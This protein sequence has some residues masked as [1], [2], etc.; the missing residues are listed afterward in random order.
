[1]LKLMIFFLFPLLEIYA[2][3]TLGG[4]I[5]GLNVVLLVFASAVLGVWVVR[6]H[7]QQCLL[8]VREELGAGRVPQELLLDNLFVFVA[9]VLL[10]LPGPISDTVGLLLLIPFVRR[11]ASV[12]LSGY[13]TAQSARQGQGAFFSGNGMFFYQSSTS[14]G[15]AQ[16]RARREDGVFDCTVKE[17]PAQDGAAEQGPTLIV[18]CDDSAAKPHGPRISQ[19][20]PHGNGQ[21]AD[22][23]SPVFDVDPADSGTRTPADTDNKTGN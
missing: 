7:G 9:G 10:I 20:G 1:M 2:L 3:A 17:V 15:P 21:G 18:D 22:A 11:M 8:R 5:G 13:L 14:Y 12:R 19:N 6:I 16:S 4:Y 23:A